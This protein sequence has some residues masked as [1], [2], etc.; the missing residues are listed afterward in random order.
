MTLAK[1]KATYFFGI[2]IVLVGASSF[3]MPTMIAP[4][5]HALLLA[6]LFLVNAGLFV[7]GQRVSG[8]DEG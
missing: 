3:V 7:M 2:I 5:P 6:G 4:W 8:K 1:A